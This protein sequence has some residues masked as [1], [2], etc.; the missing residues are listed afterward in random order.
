M[1]SW[2]RSNRLLIT[3]CK[4]DGPKFFSFGLFYYIYTVINKKNMEHYFDIEVLADRYEEEQA[5]LQELAE[6][7]SEV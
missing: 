5:L 7:L 6:E 3:F 1:L 4:K 2:W